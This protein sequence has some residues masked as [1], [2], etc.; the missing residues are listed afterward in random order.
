MKTKIKTVDELINDIEDCP[1][2]ISVIPNNMGINLVA[3][4]EIEWSRNEFGQL[5]NLTI[6]FIEGTSQE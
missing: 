6:R 1:I 2:P 3:V 5:L 4:Q